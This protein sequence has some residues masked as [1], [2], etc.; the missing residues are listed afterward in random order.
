MRIW[1]QGKEYSFKY[2]DAVS[3]MLPSAIVFAHEH[4]ALAFKLTFEV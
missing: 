1:L 4:D 3:N 2:S